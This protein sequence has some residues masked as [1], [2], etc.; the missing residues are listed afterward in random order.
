MSFPG[1]P[2]SGLQWK[3]VQTPSSRCP[4]LSPGLTEGLHAPVIPTISVPGTSF[5]AVFH[6]WGARAM[7]VQALMRVIRGQEKKLGSF[8][9]PLLTSCC[10]A[11]FQT[12]GGSD[13]STDW[14]LGPTGMPSLVINSVKELRSL[15]VKQL[16]QDHRN[17]DI[18][19]NL[20]F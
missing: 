17:G 4:C 14:G 12:G 15:E 2:R 11:P 13:E 16:L 9:H 5:M 10:A 20:F 19:V 6:G 18:S 3:T 7:M 1:C 8:S